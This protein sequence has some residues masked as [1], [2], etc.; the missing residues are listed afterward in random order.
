MEVI[1][2]DGDTN[3]SLRHLPFEAH[4]IGHV[5]LKLPR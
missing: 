1:Q 5:E 3:V 4:E 2:R